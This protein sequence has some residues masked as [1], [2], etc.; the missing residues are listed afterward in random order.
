ME[1]IGL[2]IWERLL[3][4]QGNGAETTG[5]KPLAKPG[6]LIKNNS[7]TFTPNDLL[8]LLSRFEKHFGSN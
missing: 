4:N 2:L 6:K 1:E 7:L 5:S 8:N 3:A